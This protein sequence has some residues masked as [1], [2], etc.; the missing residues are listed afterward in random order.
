MNVQP[1]N[2]A[3]TL[4]QPP[5]VKAFSVTTFSSHFVLM[6]KGQDTRD[7]WVQ[8]IAHEVAKYKGECL[9]LITTAGRS[10]RSV[11][12]DNDSSGST[13]ATDDDAILPNLALRG[14]FQ[15]GA[16]YHRHLDLMV[17]PKG[18]TSETA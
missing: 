9:A 16:E 6:V 11:V 3:D 10:Q 15:C 4:L 7:N 13:T 1:V 14:P 18:P 12:I 5:G 2:D 17:Q 8:R